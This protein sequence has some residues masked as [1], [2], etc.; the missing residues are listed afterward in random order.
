MP[1]IYKI[2]NNVNNKIYI[3]KTIR[4]LKVRFKEHLKDSNTEDNKLY[5]AMRKYGKENFSIEEIEEVTKEILSEREKFWIK[6]YNSYYNGY[7]ST[8]GGDGESSTD[9]EKI[10]ELYR[11]GKTMKE[12]SKITSHT[13]KT[14]SSVLKRN[15]ESIRKNINYCSENLYNKK[16]V[17]CIN[18]SR[19]EEFEFQ[20]MTEAANFIIKNGYTKSQNTKAVINKISLACS[21]KRQSAYG[22]IWNKK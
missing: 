2:T 22:F 1:Y 16:K 5:R 10:I 20:S 3:G 14:I 18:F 13:Q 9:E 21:G 8:F 12:I 6:K 4:S 15:F 11:L 19:T 7:N 17:S